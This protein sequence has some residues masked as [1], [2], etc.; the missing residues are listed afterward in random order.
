MEEFDFDEYITEDTEM[1]LEND[2]DFG[3]LDDEFV[4]HPSAHDG[5]DD[6]YSF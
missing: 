3:E 4:W 5:Y 2:C 6:E 1:D